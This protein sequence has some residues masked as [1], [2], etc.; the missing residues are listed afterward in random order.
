MTKKHIS[1]LADK[2]IRNNMKVQIISILILVGFLTVAFSLFSAAFDIPDGI[3]KR[4]NKYDYL[5][6]FVRDYDIDN[7]EELRGSNVN[8]IIQNDKELANIILKLDQNQFRV[9]ED[10]KGLS[11]YFENQE[12]AGLL[13]NYLDPS[14]FNE[15]YNLKDDQGRYG[16]WLYTDIFYTLGA[17]IGD[18]IEFYKEGEEDDAVKLVIKGMYDDFSYYPSLP[19]FIIP[20]NF[21]KERI[22]QNDNSSEINLLIFNYYY[23]GESLYKNLVRLAALD[24]DVEGDY[25]YYAEIQGAVYMIALL[26]AVFFVIL[27][28][29]IF[30]IYNL[31]SMIIINRSK[32]LGL[33][34]A[35]GYRD[36]DI[37][38]TY[39][40]ILQYMIIPSLVIS[41]F[42]S[43]F[44][45]NFIAETF[46]ENLKIHVTITFRWYLVILAYA[47]ICLILYVSLIFLRQ[48]IKGINIVEMI[49]E[50]V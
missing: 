22:S 18:E 39:H 16:I 27:I 46:L 19:S 31:I 13:L 11:Y 3:K 38:G 47:A 49:K 21:L 14:Y 8:I 10:E 43:Q 40:R 30:I 33:L 23:G 6:I 20:A 5:N 48:R 28:I 44:L 17:Q 37:L 35:L 4:L 32:F 50:E 7:L 15:A 36:K 24:L 34:K 9:Y 29:S 1:K 41:V 42:T 45:N 2:E 25:G 12:N 26:W